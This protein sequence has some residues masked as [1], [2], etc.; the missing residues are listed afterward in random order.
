MAEKITVSVR[1]LVEFIL[2]SG[3]IDNT[4]GYKDPDAMQEGSRI[5]RKIQK[6]M[7]SGYAAEVM[8]KMEVPLRNSGKELLLTVEGRADGVWLREGEEPEILI[9][10]I[11]SMYRDLSHI[12]EPVPVHTAQAKCYAYIYAE[13]H[14][15]EKIGIQMTYC[16]IET[17]AV[18]RFEEVFTKE[19]LKTWF[20]NLVKE[21][22]KWLFWQRDWAEQRNESIKALQFPFEYRPGQKEFVTGVYRSIL[23]EKKLFVEAPTGVGK[24]ISTVFPAVKAMGEG[25]SSKVFYLTAKTIARTVAEDT[26]AMLAE[27]GVRF[28]FVTIT[29]KEKICI[30]EKPECNPVSCPRAKGH[31]DRV[32]DA[33]FDMLTSEETI[34]RGLIEQYAE[35]HLVCPFE[36]CLDVSTWADAVVCDYNYVFDPAVSLK[37]FFA[38]EKKQDFIFLIDEAHNLVER[39]REMYSAELVK[40]DFLLA[41]RLI[42]GKSRKME[43]QLEACNAALL[44]LKRECESFQVWENVGDFIIPLLRLSAEYEDFLQEA[45]LDAEAKEAVL[46]LYFAVRQFLSVY[47]VMGEEYRIYSDYTESGDFRLKLLCMEPAKQLKERMAKGRSAVL[48]SATLLPMNYY[49][50]Q[51]GGETEDYAIYVP[52]PFDTKKRLLMIGRDVSTKYTRRNREEYEKIALYLDYFVS[53]KLGNYF[54][55]FPSYQMMEKTVELVTELLGW[56]LAELTVEEAEEAAAQMGTAGEGVQLLVQRSGM[57]EAEKEQFLEAFSERPDQRTVGFCVM[58]GIFGEGIDL[59][60]D[61]LIGTVVVGTGLPMVCDERELFRFYFDEKNGRG[62]DYAYLYPGM[63][64]VMQSAGR[65]IR[66]TEDTGAVLLLDERFL[67]GSYQNL[68]PREWFPYETVTASSMKRT[69]QN[70]W[71]KNKE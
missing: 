17:E 44:R 60:K 40:E 68:F 3:D 27:K 25:L 52:S 69:L 30:L 10:E 42:K 58:G 9:D 54:V 55:F 23:R 57:T 39:A 38:E 16:N 46:S 1:N 35:K 2:R 56:K 62:F 71:E 31:L 43:K 29:S 64:K 26:F 51:L 41:K 49:K 5:H 8:L 32:N 20:F 67:T 33:V 21:Y 53:A 47:E 34:T 48:F 12:K 14:E 65:V 37:R 7:P 59:K 66:T 11:K 28:R 15:L 13:Q 70:F 4:R 19:E 6:S 63:N 50:E 24:T 61:R 36:M 45:V 22:S 18:K